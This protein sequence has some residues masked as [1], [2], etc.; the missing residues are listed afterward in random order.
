MSATTSIHSWPFLTWS[1]G[2]LLSFVGLSIA[3]GFDDAHKGKPTTNGDPLGLVVLALVW[4]VALA[5]GA[6]VLLIQAPYHLGYRIGD[7]AR[8]REEQL[9]RLDQEV[10]AVQALLAL[11]DTPLPETPVKPVPPSNIPI[12]M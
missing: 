5:I 1:G 9:A 4:P 2:V 3:N 10:E 7:R 6:V 11:P 12:S 8:S